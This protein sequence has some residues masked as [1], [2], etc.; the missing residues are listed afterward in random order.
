MECRYINRIIESKSASSEYLTEAKE[1]HYV[2]YT[3]KYLRYGN[4]EVSI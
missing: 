2:A 1:A 4:G 3:G